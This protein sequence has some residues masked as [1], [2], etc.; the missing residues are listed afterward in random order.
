VAGAA[1]I[2]LRVGTVT[3]FAAL[4]YLQGKVIAH[5]AQKHTHRQWLEF[6]KEI[7][8]LSLVPRSVLQRWP[9]H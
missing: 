9:S 3:L 7:D 2:K 5:T 4:D 8:R 6:L 1:G